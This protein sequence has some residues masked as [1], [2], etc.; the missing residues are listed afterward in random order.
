MFIADLEIEFEGDGSV[1]SLF[2]KNLREY[3]RIGRLA[4]PR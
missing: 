3:N 4:M 2:M 1:M